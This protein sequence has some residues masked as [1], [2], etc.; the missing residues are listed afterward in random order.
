MS[1]MTHSGLERGVVD[2]PLH[3][4]SGWTE[5]A[6]QGTPDLIQ[7]C[8]GFD[9]VVPR[10]LY[11][12]S[13]TFDTVSLTES[14]VSSLPYAETSELVP[15]DLSVNRTNSSLSRGE[16]FCSLVKSGVEETPIEDNRVYPPLEQMPLEQFNQSVPSDLR[17][18]E[19]ILLAYQVYIWVSG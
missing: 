2:I 4:V 10:N 7:T 18:I 8:P 17:A 6:R 12:S 14:V 1:G 19:R 16:L 11:P 9:K 3:H 13:D 5:P 15:L